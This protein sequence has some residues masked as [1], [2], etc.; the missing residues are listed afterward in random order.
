[1]PNTGARSLLL[2]D[3][4]TGHCPASLN[5]HIPA[6][7]VAEILTIPKKTTGMVQPLDVYGFRIWKA[8]VRKFSDI[9]ILENYN[10]DLHQRNHVIKMQSLIH[11]QLSAPKF[12]NLFAYAWYKSGYL[13]IRPG[14]FEHPVAF[15]FTADDA[16]YRPVCSVCGKKGFIKCAKCDQVLCFQ[17]FYEEYHFHQE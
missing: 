13:D 10:V 12:Q 17:H 6:D 16:G 7:K 9:V 5:P 15:A 3:S 8:F 2:L 11:N 14:R 4:W 1:M